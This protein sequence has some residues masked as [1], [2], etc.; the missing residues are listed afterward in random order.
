MNNKQRCENILEVLKNSN[1]EHVF[2]A[3]KVLED[4][5]NCLE[6]VPFGLR[7]EPIRICEDLSDGVISGNESIKKLVSFVKAVKSES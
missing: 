4:E 7:N 2:D 1:F 6:S 5:I 3:L